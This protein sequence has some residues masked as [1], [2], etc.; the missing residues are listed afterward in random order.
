MWNL[1]ENNLN[2]YGVEKILRENM[3]DSNKSNFGKLLSAY[4]LKKYL[5]LDFEKSEEE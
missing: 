5:N 4:D 3:L 2:L 1:N